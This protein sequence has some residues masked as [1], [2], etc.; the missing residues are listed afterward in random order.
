[1]VRDLERP[2]LQAGTS[3]GG[4]AVFQS[5]RR[6]REMIDSR[7]AAWKNWEKLDGNREGRTRR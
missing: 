5:R 6:W 3:I 4:I 2:G 7:D 1:M